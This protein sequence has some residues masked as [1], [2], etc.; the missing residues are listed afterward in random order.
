MEEQRKQAQEAKR[1][2]KTIPLTGAEAD[3]DW[4]TWMDMKRKTRTEPAPPPKIDAAILGK[5]KEAKTLGTRVLSPDERAQVFDILT[6]YAEMKRPLSKSARELRYYINPEV[7]VSFHM[8]KA[9]L[10]DLI[11][12]LEDLS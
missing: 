10:H 6:A 12:I 9:Q 11:K 5:L 3:D 2:S 8:D 4:R 1:R 7:D